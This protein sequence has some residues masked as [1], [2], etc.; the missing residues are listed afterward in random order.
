MQNML[1]TLNAWALGIGQIAAAGPGSPDEW[2]KELSNVT[3]MVTLVLMIAV[4]LGGTVYCVILGVNL[5]RAEDAEKRDEAKKRLI[6][7]LV[8]IGAIVVLS[9]ILNIGFRLPDKP[10][11]EIS[12]G[13]TGVGFIINFFLP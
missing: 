12:K 10:I 9:L 5:A 11:E 2:V 4:G 13:D 1:A 7:A 6:W 3:S 8:G